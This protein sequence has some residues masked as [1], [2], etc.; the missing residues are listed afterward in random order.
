MLSRRSML[1]AT[2]AAGIGLTA[3][4]CGSSSGDAAADGP[5]D[6]E[7]TDLSGEITLLTPDF[8][9]DARPELDAMIAQFTD[10]NPEVS[11]TVDQVAW[12]KL[13]EKL[14]TSIAGGLVA[15]VIMSGVGWTPPFAQKKIFA[16][17]PSDYVGGLGISDAL[18]SSCTYEDKYFSLPIGMDLRFVVYNTE[19]FEAKGITEAPTTMDELAQVGEEL[20]GDGVVGFDLLTKNIRQGWIHMLYAFGGTLFTED[21]LASA[22]HEEPGAQAT[23]WILD[24]MDKGAIDYNL[25]AA[26]GQPT[27][28]MQGTAAMQL[29][30]TADWETWRTMSPELMEEGAV[31][32]F[33]LPGGNGNEPVMFQGGTMVSVGQR[34]QNQAAAA[35]LVKH[36]M[37]PEMLAA[38]NAATGK[39][40][41]T[42][43]FPET[44]EITDNLLTAFALEHL[45][46][47][48][49]AEGGSPAW[50]EIR[51]NLQ[52]IIEGCLTGQ[53]DVDK[54]LAD[55][56]SLADDAISR[57]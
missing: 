41:P 33:L 29:V 57:L 26:E 25:Q 23:Q 20:T 39:V 46:K 35:A 43:D 44:P 52:P 31:G 42:T 2:G 10:Q 21:G 22:M 49:A 7:G 45:D 34:S 11:V 53:T 18:L 6:L 50:M 36:L 48:G 3:A 12:D 16:E 1:S 13:N 32:M 54:T 30:S 17:L 37:T 40:P 15:D 19:M 8:V 55:M 51:G 27:P 14:S 38:G 24:Q 9:G 4:A 28:F 5:V 47:A 56:K